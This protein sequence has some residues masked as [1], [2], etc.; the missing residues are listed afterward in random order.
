MCPGIRRN[1]A[2]SELTPTGLR[3]GHKF[4]HQPGS[5]WETSEVTRVWAAL[6]T[7]AV[8]HSP[9]TSLTQRIRQ[10]APTDSLLR[11]NQIPLSAR[12]IAKYVKIRSAPARLIAP[13][14]SRTTRP[15]SM[16]PAWAPNLIIAYSPLT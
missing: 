11:M 16:A 2:Q 4:A 3:S 8:G 10:Q 6:R 12:S 5:L 15:S 14:L 7:N 1:A 9:S 13:R